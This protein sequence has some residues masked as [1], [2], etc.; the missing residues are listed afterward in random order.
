MERN[1]RRKYL[2]K[3]KEKSWSVI[4]KGVKRHKHLTIPAEDNEEQLSEFRKDIV[5]GTIT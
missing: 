3:S 5:G 1:V 4:F 2:R